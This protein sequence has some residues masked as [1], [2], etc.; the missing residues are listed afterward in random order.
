MEAVQA[1]ASPAGN[2]SD[3]LVN[4]LKR[5]GRIA[6]AV[7]FSVIAGGFVCLSLQWASAGLW[8][9]IL[10]LAPIPYALWV[11]R[12]L[13]VGLARQGAQ[14]SPPAK[15]SLIPVVISR[16]ILAALLIVLHGPMTM[17]P[18][19]LMVGIAL[20]MAVS[21]KPVATRARFAKAAI[22]GLATIAVYVYVSHDRSQGDMLVSKLEEYKRQHGAYPERLDAMVPALLPAIPKPGLK[23]GFQ[24]A[25]QEGS[26]AYRL[27][28][29]PSV[30][31]PCSYAPESGKWKCQAR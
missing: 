2:D 15:V 27:S 4:G 29:S 13:Q 11:N 22:Y 9:F 17:G 6:L 7:T 18:L 10:G 30:A 21:G 24:Y 14:G 26:G 12:K 3:A 20:V 8:M 5:R 1:V 28:Y 31:G 19:V 16:G 25:R 23:G